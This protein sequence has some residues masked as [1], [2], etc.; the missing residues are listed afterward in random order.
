MTGPPGIEKVIYSQSQGITNCPHCGRYVGPLEICPFCRKIHRKRP[1]VFWTKYL[2]PILAIAGLFGLKLM[3]DSIGNPLMKIG[4]LGRTS[5]FAYIQLE[6][7]VCGEP[8]FYHAAG[9][10][11]P[12]AG[13][14]EFCLDDGTGQTRVKTYE[15]ATRRILRERKVPGQGDTVHVTGNF[16]TRTHKHSLIV[17]SPH[18]I[19][20]KPTPVS[21]R[22]TA[23]EL[24][25]A[26]PGAFGD[27]PRVVVEG[28]VRK[29][30]NDREKGK[31]TVVLFLDGGKRKDDQGHY[32]QVRVELPWAKLEMDGTMPRNA[33]SWDGIPAPGTK[34][35]V[36]GTAKYKQDKKYPGWR[37]YLSWATDIEVVGGKEVAN[38]L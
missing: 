2:T 8:R 14:M 28:T 4:D 15:D 20:I 3:G 21:A 37:L 5:N 27:E 25:W 38:E 13:T 36:T 22:L 11:D 24:A 19:E 30:W 32:R 26:D 7:T 33:N 16:Q 31:Y 6:G 35:R 17:G 34:L 9:S 23:E 29:S 18:E 12:T 1:I 10:D